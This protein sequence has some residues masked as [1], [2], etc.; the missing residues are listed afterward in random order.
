MR[1]RLSVEINNMA[2]GVREHLAELRLPI[3]IL[4]GSEDKLVNPS[5]SQL[6]YDR[7]SSSDKTLKM[8]PGM[9]HEIMNEIG[10]EAVLDEIVTWLDQHV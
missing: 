9:R 1:V 3:L 8:Y 4:H 5:G 7:V 10:K 6:T 2:R